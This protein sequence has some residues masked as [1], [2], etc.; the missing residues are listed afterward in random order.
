MADRMRTLEVSNKALL[1]EMVHIHAAMRRE[2][3]ETKKTLSE[4]VLETSRQHKNCQSSSD[5]VMSHNKR[6]A[7]RVTRLER[8]LLGVEG[9]LTHT[10]TDK[11]KQETW[12][13]ER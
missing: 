10:H 9:V 2:K 11:E 13:K 1:E 7:D 8:S 12:L 3:E 4:V 5:D 6:M